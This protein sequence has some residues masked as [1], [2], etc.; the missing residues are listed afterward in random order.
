MEKENIQFGRISLITTIL[1][2][3]A[4]MTTITTLIYVKV[5]VKPLPFYILLV[6]FMMSFNK[7]S[8]FTLMEWWLQ[9]CFVNIYR[10]G[11]TGK[12]RKGTAI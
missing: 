1:G 12:R 4:I 10:L 8:V 2:A 6:I 5:F 7:F 11:R 3:L 9:K